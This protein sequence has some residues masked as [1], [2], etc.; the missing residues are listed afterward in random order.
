SLCKAD[1]DGGRS[2]T[3]QKEP[4]S[5]NHPQTIAKIG[6]KTVWVHFEVHFEEHLVRVRV[7]ANGKDS[8]GSGSRANRRVAAV[9]DEMS[10][11]TPAL[12]LGLEGDLL[13]PGVDMHI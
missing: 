1:T 3:Q 11:W 13:H 7:L 8:L 2:E 12:L 4:T 10:D 9:V 5:G 6:R